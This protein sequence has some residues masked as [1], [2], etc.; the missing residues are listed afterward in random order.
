MTVS[1]G[2]GIDSGKKGTV[3]PWKGNRD[4]HSYKDEDPKT[5]VRIRFEDGSERIIPKNRATSEAGSKGKGVYVAPR[6]AD[7]NSEGF[8]DPRYAGMKNGINESNRK[9]GATKKVVKRSLESRREENSD[10]EYSP[11]SLNYAP[12]ERHEGWRG[13][14]YSPPK[15]N[16]PEDLSKIVIKEF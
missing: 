7:N 1:Q 3:I 4:E 5:N 12:P 15:I 8:V 6:N 9:R 16:V 13:G 14:S 2:S 10:A 11:I